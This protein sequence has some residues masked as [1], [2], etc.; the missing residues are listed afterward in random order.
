MQAVTSK[1][2]QL[3]AGEANQ[4]LLAQAVAIYQG[5]LRQATAATKTRG[6]INR[7]KKKWFKQKGTGNARHGA[8]TPALFVGG[9]VAHG[10]NGEQNYKRSLPAKMKKAALRSAFLLQSKNC[11]IDDKISSVDG[12]TKSAV[13][14]LGDKL[15]DDRRVLLVVTQ[16]TPEVLRAFNNLEMVYVTTSDYV[17]TLQVANADTIVMTKDALNA[18]EQRLLPKNT[19]KETK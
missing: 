16:K 8:Q 9:G 18:L 17:N 6:N 11:F 13:A 4:A 3:F 5:N 2:S 10:P 7:T 14:A 12:K 19:N 1:T 15:T